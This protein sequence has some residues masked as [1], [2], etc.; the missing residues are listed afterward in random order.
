MLE[1]LA[2]HLVNIPGRRG[3]EVSSRQGRAQSVTNDIGVQESLGPRAVVA[4]HEVPVTQSIEIPARNVH[5]R[6]AEPALD[7]GARQAV[8]M[9]HDIDTVG[10]GYR[11]AGKSG[12]Y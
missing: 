3:S 9:I 4:N 1:R 2:R 12:G 8:K 6:G 5:F 10:L 11:E 7:G